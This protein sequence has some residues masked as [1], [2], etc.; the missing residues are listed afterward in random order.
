MSLK[1]IIYELIVYIVGDT[2]RVSKCHE[3]L[4]SI[5]DALTPHTSKIG[6]KVWT[7]KKRNFLLSYNHNNFFLPLYR[8]AGNFSIIFV[9]YSVCFQI[10]C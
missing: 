2:E 4:I 1:D 3:L 8:H 6:Q 7:Q 9:P 5:K 10:I